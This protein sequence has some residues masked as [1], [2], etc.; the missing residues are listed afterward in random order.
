VTYDAIRSAD[1][2]DAPAEASVGA[3]ARVSVFQLSRG[4]FLLPCTGSGGGFLFCA[5]SGGGPFA[6]YGRA[7]IPGD[8][9]FRLEI[10]G[11]CGSNSAGASGAGVFGSTATFGG[12]E[13]RAAEARDVFGGMEVRAAGARDAFGGMEVR[14]AGARDVFGDMEV[15]A[16]GARDAFGRIEARE[17]GATDF[18]G[19]GSGAGALAI[20]RGGDTA[21]LGGDAVGSGEAAVGASER[22]GPCVAGRGGFC[23]ASGGIDR[24]AI[25]A[26]EPGE[27]D[28][29]LG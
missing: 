11:V 13:V 29:R 9:I 20:D 5:G 23:F 3:S 24:R 14:A 1:R 16:A 4:G 19:A 28:G 15:R 27:M 2:G 21:F 22:R 10:P 8:E 7:E 26:R 6:T 25:A 18:R 17:R 12:M